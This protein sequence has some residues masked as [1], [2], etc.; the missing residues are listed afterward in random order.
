MSRTFLTGA[1]LV[2]NDRLL[3]GHSL[4]VEDGLVAE[5][6]PEH[7]LPD[8]HDVEVTLPGRLVVPGFI[9][10]HVHG[11]AGVD[12]LDDADAVARVAA[13]LPRWGVT[14]F[15]P[16]SLACS[17]DVLRVFL[18]AVRGT[19]GAR[20]V[21]SAKVLPAHLESNF[22]N[23]DFRGAQ[24]A[25]A[26][27]LPDGEVVGGYSGADILRVIFDHVPQVGI[28]TLAPERAGGLDLVRRLVSAGV[29]V[30]V[31][32][33]GA[34][35]DE[36]RA[37]FDAGASRA[38]H[39]YSAMPPFSHRDPG[40]VGAV[41]SNPA[42]F[43]ELICDGVHVH[44]IAMQITLAAKSLISNRGGDRRHGRVWATEGI[45]GSPRGQTYYGRRRRAL[46]RR[47]DGR[48]CSDDGSR[49]RDA[50]DALPGGPRDGRATLRHSSRRGHAA[51]SHRR[52]RA[53]RAG[54]S[55]RDRAGFR[56]RADMDRRRVRVADWRRQ[57]VGAPHLAAV[58]GMVWHRS[59]ALH[60]A[61][62]TR[63]G[64]LRRFPDG[65]SGVPEARPLRAP[66]VRPT[67]ADSRQAA[68]GRAE[69]HRHAHLET[70]V[71]PASRRSQNVGRLEPRHTADRISCPRRSASGPRPPLRG[72]RRAAPGT[73]CSGRNGRS[74]SGSCTIT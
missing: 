40:V 20:P 55:G 63:T 70:A 36:A 43:A 45:A 29:L 64:G 52:Y 12:V 57:P 41:L 53:R 69:E 56:R 35:F 10:L 15:S 61:R 50:G 71:G 27:R 17:P 9:D 67:P 18:D 28:V 49:L 60:L 62:V 5:I 4:V 48:K 1:T 14:A 22:L 65:C 7:R 39:L 26:L 37:A 42:V 30:S 59:A 44:P 68:S 13:M 21:G 47:C 73:C 72:R 74:E 6:V 19:E 11:V 34:T 38:T 16:T 25:E 54:R 46:G 31:G 32:H 33:T 51:W 58:C 3:T 23:P 24:P 66:R 8:S 2:V